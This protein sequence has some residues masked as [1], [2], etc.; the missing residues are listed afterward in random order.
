M[1]R[2]FRLALATCCCAFAV[3]P[4]A[5]KAQSVDVAFILLQES[6]N[7]L[8]RDFGNEN[9][10]A[11]E[12]EE[13]LVDG[14]RQRVGLLEAAF[15]QAS[16][17]KLNDDVYALSLAENTYFINLA[18]ASDDPDEITEALEIVIEDLELKSEPL[19]GQ[20]LDGSINTKPG[21]TVYVV[22][23][24]GNRL[25]GFD[26]GHLPGRKSKMGLIPDFW[27]EPTNAAVCPDCT[28]ARFE[29]V[30]K[31]GDTILRKITTV[32][33]GNTQTVVVITM[34]EP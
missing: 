11:P 5:A 1:G 26:V 33:A 29:F 7:D 10:I 13:R 31:R 9:I 20:G 21:V 19:P 17:D 14:L 25:T 23:A 34:E 30:A 18:I 32:G 3:I 8:E 2:V 6:I 22:D 12:V 15:D 24:E 28:P 4:G 16:E 27:P